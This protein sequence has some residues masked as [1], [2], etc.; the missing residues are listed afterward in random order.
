[1][2]HHIT[3]RFKKFKDLFKLKNNKK[4]KI[5]NRIG[6]NKYIVSIFQYTFFV[7]LS[8][9]LLLISFGDIAIDMILSFIEL[10]IATKGICRKEMI[11][12]EHY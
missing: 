3:Q 9:F 2:G 12:K 4:A 1:M 8:L 7:L 6:I 11:V 5:P 10:Q